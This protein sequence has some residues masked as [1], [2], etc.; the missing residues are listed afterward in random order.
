LSYVNKMRESLSL[1]KRFR[2]YSDEDLSV[3][4]FCLLAERD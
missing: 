4:L 1:Y 3:L 2:K